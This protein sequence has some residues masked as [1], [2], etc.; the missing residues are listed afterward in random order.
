MK[1][2]QFTINFKTVTVN[3]EKVKR[4]P[5]TVDYNQIEESDIHDLPHAQIAV[6]LNSA[7]QDYAR[8]LVTA[9]SDNWEY[10][11]NA[12]DLTI[13]AVYD[14]LTSPSKRGQRLITKAKLAEFAEYYQQSAIDLLGKSAKAAANGAMAITAKF[15]PLLGNDAAIEAFENNLIALVNHDEFDTD[16]YG[17]LLAAL[18]EIL[19]DIKK[20][21]ELSADDY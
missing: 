4:D 18:I 9:N 17:E 3:G 5:L 15:V 1:Q 11:P 20:P 6:I 2:S 14:D 10:Q 21:V 7:I 12:D 16:Q 19:S 8:K 13:A